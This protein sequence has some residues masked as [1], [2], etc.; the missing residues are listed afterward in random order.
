MIAKSFKSR[1]GSFDD[2]YQSIDNFSP[3]D[4]SDNLNFNVL[5]DKIVHENK[6]SF[7]VESILNQE[8]LKE[9]SEYCDLGPKYGET[10]NQTDNIRTRGINRYYSTES[11]YY[12]DLESIYEHIYKPIET[13][14]KNEVMKVTKSRIFPN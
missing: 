13:N 6:T 5:N 14:V 12:E 3:V 2:V 11:I 8:Y 7:P 10:V 1:F 9:Y 4:H